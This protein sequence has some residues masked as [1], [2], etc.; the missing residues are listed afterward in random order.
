MLTAQRVAALRRMGSE[1]IRARRTSGDLRARLVAVAQQRVQIGD[2]AEIERVRATLERSSR[3][4]DERIRAMEAVI[5]SI[6]VA[7]AES[8]PR[9]PAARTP[10]LAGA[11]DAP[12][13]GG[14]VAPTVAP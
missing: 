12:V 5:S 2:Q 10:Q 3:A 13:R 1:Y 14:W 11:T 9:A 8:A 7:I 4:A 6:A